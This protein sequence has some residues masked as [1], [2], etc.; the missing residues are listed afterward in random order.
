MNFQANFEF[1]NGK[2]HLLLACCLTFLSSMAATA[3]VDADEEDLDLLEP[4]LQN[5][6]DQKSLR[7]IFV[8]GKGGVGKTTTSCCVATLL[9]K[10]RENVLIISTD[11]A[12]NLSDAFSQK[13]TN[14]PT[15]VEGFDN[16]FCMEIDT[17]VGL[18]EMQ[19]AAAGAGADGMGG[20]VPGAGD[21]GGIQSMFKDLSSAVPGIDECMS[22]A[23]LMKQ[24]QTMDFSCIVFDTA[25]T[26]HTLRLLSFPSVLEKAFEKFMSTCSCPP[27]KACLRPADWTYLK[28]H[29]SNLTKPL[30]VLL[31]CSCLMVRAAFCGFPGFLLAPPRP[32]TF[33]QPDLKNR[34]SGMF[35]QFSGLLGAN[36]P[37]PDAL[38]EKLEQTR[39]I[40]EQ[41]NRQFKDPECTTFVCVCIPVSESGPF[42]VTFVSSLLVFLFCFWKRA[43]FSAFILVLKIAAGAFNMD[44]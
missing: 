19:L 6:V 26:G 43:L 34:F 38:L 36:M 24:V 44:G 41:V 9:A 30:P 15:K 32:G 8:G 2:Q 40:I 37:S 12:H 10:S 5:I 4:S 14:K 18:E 11:P 25:P 21:M 33:W 1:V 13:F 42:F 28:A 3:V 16:L 20:G 35:S 39:A 29:A 27:W 31:M 22:F 23:E 7:W 17:S